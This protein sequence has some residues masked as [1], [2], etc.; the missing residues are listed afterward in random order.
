VTTT[1]RRADRSAAVRQAI[2]DAAARLFVE[3]GFAAASV[4]DIAREAGTDPA[5]VIRH[6]GSKEGL[7]LETMAFPDFWAHVLEGPI[8]NIGEQLARAVIE[9]RGSRLGVYTALI[10][11]SDR[12]E[13]RAR[14]GS[15]MV[16]TFV[17]PV[18]ERLQSPDAA[19]RARLFAAQLDGL[20]TALAIRQDAVLLAT[21]VDELVRWYGPMLQSALTGSAPAS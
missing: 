5:L 18:L 1:D 15:S 17:E 9:A 13:V 10:R 21:P 19:L 6:F 20:L 8:E 12:P 16:L 14:L 2:R 11:A 3:Q 4:R 7:F